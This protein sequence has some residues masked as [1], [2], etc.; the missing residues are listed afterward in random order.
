MIKYLMRVVV[1]AS[2]IIQGHSNRKIITFRDALSVLENF[3]HKTGSKHPVA[4]SSHFSRDTK[5]R[6]AT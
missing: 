6:G 4:A 2:P 3:C 1:V 5:F